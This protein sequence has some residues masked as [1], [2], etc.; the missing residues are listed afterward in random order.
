MSS[1]PNASSMTVK[2]RVTIT[3]YGEG[4]KT[5]E[6]DMSYSANSNTSTAIRNYD[7]NGSTVLSELS[8]SNF[9]NYQE[10]LMSCGSSSIRISSGGTLYGGDGIHFRG[11]LYTYYNNRWQQVVNYRNV[12]VGSST[13]T[14]INGLLVT[15]Q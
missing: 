10:A 6:I 5:N 1:N 8:I 13:L 3:N 12:I 11:D 15:V 14:F 2:N 7:S 9:V 4:K